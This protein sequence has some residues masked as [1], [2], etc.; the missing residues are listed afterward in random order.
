VC[1]CV[2]VCVAVP[3]VDRAIPSNLRS[4]YEERLAEASVAGLE[5]LVR[6]P[7]CVYAGER[8]TDRQTDTQR[9]REIIILSCSR[10]DVN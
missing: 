3:Q 2:C 1:V 8:E 5:G 9:E 6:C 10:A 7:F 4:K